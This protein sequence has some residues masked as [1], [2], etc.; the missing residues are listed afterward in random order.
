MFGPFL[1]DQDTIDKVVPEGI[2]GNYALGHIEDDSFIVEYV[3]RSDT[4]LHDRLP[5]ELGKYTHF[6]FSSAASAIEAYQK[7]CTN[8]HE[9]GGE[10]KYLANKIH[11]DKPD[12]IKFAFCPICA[13]RILDKINKK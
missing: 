13:R 5:H 1:Y 6:K 2:I 8:W 11:P 3:G 7:E 4:D 9:F 10:K 12:N